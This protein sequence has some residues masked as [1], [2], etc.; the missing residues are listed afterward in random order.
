MDL[1]VTTNQKLIIDTQMKKRKESKHNTKDS[2]QILRERSKRTNNQELEKQPENK[3]Q[4][5]NVF[6]T[7]EIQ[8]QTCQRSSCLRNPGVCGERKVTLAA[9]L[10]CKTTLGSGEI[11]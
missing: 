5:G 6:K 4:N 2:H 8:G 1:M 11:I 9:Q 7:P 10:I 3:L